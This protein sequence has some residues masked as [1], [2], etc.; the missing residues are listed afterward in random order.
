MVNS[1]GEIRGGR[2]FI[3]NDWYPGSLPPNV[4]LEESA[5]LETAYSFTSFHSEMEDGFVMGFASGSYAFG[6]YLVGKEGSVNIG[7][8]V[9]LNSANIICN[10]KISVGDHCMLGWGTVVCDS[11]VNVD[12]S[13]DTERKALLLNAAQSYDRY[14]DLSVYAKPIII[15]N[16]VWVGFDAV[17]MPGVRLGEGCIIGCKTVIYHDVPSYAVVAGNPSRITKYLQ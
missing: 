15:E 7:K 6:N 1:I 2:F 10:E 8:Y 16:N 13:A 11:W 12:K 5:Y 17:I 14:V 3:F 4:V 9:I